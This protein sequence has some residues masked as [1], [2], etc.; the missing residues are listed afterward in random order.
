MIYYKPKDFRETQAKTHLIFTKYYVSIALFG[1]G[2]R[3][4]K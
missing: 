1:Y 2:L 3:Y 4:D